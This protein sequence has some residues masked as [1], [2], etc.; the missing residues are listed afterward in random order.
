M[1]IHDT[2]ERVCADARSGVCVVRR[3]AQTCVLDNCSCVAGAQLE[4]IVRLHPNVSVLVKATASGFLV[5]FSDAP[6]VPVLQSSDFAELLLAGL[7][8]VA[9]ASLLA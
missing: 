5:V 8:V 2:V 1:H 7:C 6:H 9:V 4:E 3:D